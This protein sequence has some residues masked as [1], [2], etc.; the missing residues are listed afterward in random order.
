MSL[1]EQGARAIMADSIVH[2]R[3][4]LG[5]YETRVWAILMI[6][7]AFWANIVRTSNADG[8]M[9][10]AGIANAILDNGAFDVFAWA[11]V[12]ARFVAGRD[13]R[14][15]TP[16]AVLGTFALGVIVLIPAR[17]PCALAL[18][19]LGCALLT[20][21][22]VP[23]SVRRTSL[24]QFALAFEIVWMS[25]FL[26]P[27][28]VLVASVDARITSALL[29]TIGDMAASHGN[30]VENSATDFSIVIWN[31]CSS[32]FPLAGVGLAFVVL[33]T[34]RGKALRIAHLPWLAASFVASAV[35]TEIRLV[36]LGTDEANYHWWHSGPG[37]SIYALAALGLSVLFP[38]L[39]TSPAADAGPA[40]R[41]A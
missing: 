37:V 16:R 4:R 9:A 3:T 25:P 15:A 6:G 5:A 26:A 28:H 34:Y 12:L 35:L 41:A 17:L 20:E 32:S 31:Y 36:L 13:D 2:R 33:V 23:E 30:V 24:I 27:L 38:V 29:G 19:I 18:A 39:A 21:R 7:F 1:P 22:D 10:L 14:P 11:L 40:A 8:A